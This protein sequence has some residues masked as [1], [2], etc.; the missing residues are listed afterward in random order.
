MCTGGFKM[1][2]NIKVKNFKSLK[3]VS[4]EA[5]PLNLLAG[6]NGIGKSTL[7]QALLLLKQCE[8]QKISLN[9]KILKLG[10][11][12]DILYQ[13]SENENIKFML[14]GKNG[15]KIEISIPIKNTE[16]DRPNYKFQGDR[17]FL[18]K[19]AKKIKYVGADRLSPQSSHG[20]SLS[21]VQELD[22]GVHGEFAV[23]LLSTLDKNLHIIKDQKL[24]DTLAAGKEPFLTKVNK[25][26]QEIAPN[27]RTRIE[28]RSTDLKLSFAF[29]LENGMA[30]NPCSPENTGFGI[31]YVLPIIVAL[32]IP[33]DED[34]LIIE[35]PESHIHPRGQ[36]KLGELMARAASSGKQI[37]VETHSD[38]II[39]GVRVAVKEKIIGEKDVKIAFFEKQE[40]KDEQYA[41]IREIKIEENGSLSD[42]PDGFMDEWANQLLNLA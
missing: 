30:T 29:Q 33:A 36:A 14:T 11:A 32:L 42:Y 1:I 4:L 23:H 13:F 17:E 8:A 28:E 10:T 9:G 27:V 20:K 35:N 22:T 25:W 24:K 37:F 15:K 12:G 19:L 39:N 16:D 40:E 21:H 41:K 34:V 5:S 38:H 18:D 2:S 26:L 31:S 7:V 3:D 6:L